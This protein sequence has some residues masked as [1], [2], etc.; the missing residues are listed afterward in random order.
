VFNATCRPLYLKGKHPVLTVQEAVWAPGSVWTGAENLAST[1]IRSLDRP[2]S[3]YTDHALS[4]HILS[5]LIKIQLHL[6]LFS[7]LRLNTQMD[8][9]FQGFPTKTALLMS[10]IRPTCSTT[11]HYLT[12]PLELF[13]IVLFVYIHTPKSLMRLSRSMESTKMFITNSI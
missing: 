5:Y 8:S 11:S 2:K 13:N 3:R 10:P 4:A 6:R 9:C 7:D 1:G 12:F